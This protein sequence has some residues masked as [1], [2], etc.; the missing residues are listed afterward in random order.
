M[1]ALIQAVE[2]SFNDPSKI[3]TIRNVTKAISNLCWPLPELAV[4]RPALPVLAQSLLS[5][6]LEIV[7]DACWAIGHISDGPEEYI[8][9]ILERDS[10][11]VPRLIELM[12]HTSVKIVKQAVKSIGNIICVN[13]VLI[14]QIVGPLSS[15]LES[16]DAD[17]RNEVMLVISNITD[18]TSEQIQ[19]AIDAGIFP[20]LFD[21]LRTSE[22][23]V[24]SAGIWA[25]CN[26][27]SG[28]TP[29]QIRYLMNEGVISLLTDLSRVSGMSSIK[30]ALEKFQGYNR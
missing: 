11:L 30:V 14:Q 4:I 16:S 9:A 21:L 23:D 18:G 12:G 27:T 7:S 8:R 20:K 13:E 28:G 29:E 5:E 1:P 2:G 19:Y 15:L 6:D 26:V 17:V 25:I 10:D 22:L 3:E 24:R